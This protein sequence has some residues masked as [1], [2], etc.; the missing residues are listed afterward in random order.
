MSLNKIPIER[1]SGGTG[2]SVV[3]PILLLNYQ[4]KACRGRDHLVEYLFP[5]LRAARKF[6]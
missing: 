5:N 4:E 1:C 6:L 3:K 2:V